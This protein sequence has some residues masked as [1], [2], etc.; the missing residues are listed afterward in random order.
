MVIIFDLDYTLLDTKKF[1][2]KMAGILKPDDFANDYKK[3]KRQK[4]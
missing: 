2:D 4:Y 3:Y 1:K